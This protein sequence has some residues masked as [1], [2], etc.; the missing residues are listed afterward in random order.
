MPM[1]RFPG[2]GDKR[3]L[4]AAALSWALALALAFWR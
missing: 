2:N 4:V 3:M 1:K